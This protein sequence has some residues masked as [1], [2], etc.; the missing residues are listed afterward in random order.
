[1]RRARGAAAAAAEAGPRLLMRRATAGAAVTAAAARALLLA[2]ACAAAALRVCA[3]REDALIVE[4]SIE[5]ET[6]AALSPFFSS[7]AG[8]VGC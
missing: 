1:M 2:E 4:R 6:P 5:R 8:V 3:A 7:G